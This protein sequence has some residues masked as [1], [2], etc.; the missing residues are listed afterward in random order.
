[1]NELLRHAVDEYLQ[2]MSV[3][4]IDHDDRDVR[5]LVDVDRSG[6]R[7]H[8]RARV[9][10]RVVRRFP[11]E[12]TDG[13]M[14]VTVAASALRRVRIR[15]IAVDVDG[16]SVMIVGGDDRAA[17]VLGLDPYLERHGAEP[18]DDVPE[19]NGVAERNHAER[20]HAVEIHRRVLGRRRL[21]HHL[22]ESETIVRSVE[23]EVHAR[24]GRVEG[25]GRLVG[26]R[27]RAIA[28]RVRAVKVED[29]VVRNRVALS[30]LR[31]R[32]PSVPGDLIHGARRAPQPHARHVTVERHTPRAPDDVAEGQISV[33]GAPVAESGEV[34]HPRHLSGGDAIDVERHRRL[35]RRVHDDGDVGPH[36]EGNAPG[37]ARH[38]GAHR[39]GD[40]VA[41]P[42]RDGPVDVAGTAPIPVASAREEHLPPRVTERHQNLGAVRG[43]GFYPRLERH[44][45]ACAQIRAERRVVRNRRRPAVEA[46][47]RSG[48]DAQRTTRDPLREGDRQ[49]LG[50]VGEV[51]DA[52]GVADDGGAGKVEMRAKIAVVCVARG[53]AEHPRENL[54]GR[55]S[56]GPKANV[57]HR[58]LEATARPVVAGGHGAAE[59]DSLGLDGRA[60]RR[61]RA[62]SGGNAVDEKRHRVRRGVHRHRHVAPTPR[63]HADGGRRHVHALLAGDSAAAAHEERDGTVHVRPAASG[64]GSAGSILARE[65]DA[66]LEV[67]RHH[68]R[69][70]RLDAAGLDPRL[71][72]D[73]GRRGGGPNVVL[74]D[75]RRLTVEVHRGIP[76]DED[77]SLRL[78]RLHLRRARLRRRGGRSRRRRRRAA[79]EL[80]PTR[81]PGPR[82]GQD[83]RRLP[84]L[85]GALVR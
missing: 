20:V 48:A 85:R 23:V 42:K 77:A 67:S 64:A 44:D 13:V 9:G 14:R 7:R 46:K 21:G 41:W 35:A 29:E 68:H 26:E 8:I 74:D 84:G 50:G 33:G 55:Q 63:R 3:R 59:R 57:V 17:V 78:R 1:M 15:G 49:R 66:P 70:H 79:L 28:R 24:H 83:F 76:S 52:K 80:P 51:D 11:R 69:L 75:A 16:P 43:V 62:R 53:D 40:G 47:R 32:E 2:T 10:C 82:A 45:A 61:R 71:E 27:A 6:C 54:L 58:A 73:E 22:E 38:V 39:A 18:P 25:V 12:E 34:L 31:Q 19:P 36:V 72:S 5:P 56:R 37:R 30:V 65:H 60:E 81:G 4:A